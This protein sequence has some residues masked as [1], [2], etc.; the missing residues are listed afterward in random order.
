MRWV[1]NVE[2]VG[3]NAH[4]RSIGSSEGKWQ[5]GRPR[6]GWKYNVE[7]DL[8]GIQ[9]DGVE[10]I[11]LARDK[12]NGRAVVNTVMN[13]GVLERTGMSRLSEQL[14]ACTACSYFV[15]LR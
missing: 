12:E 5:F 4:T 3:K 14:S 10:G 2:Y 7:M 9:F 8:K 15:R 13:T 11:H 1:Q 6:R